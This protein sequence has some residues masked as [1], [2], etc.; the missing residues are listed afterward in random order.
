MRKFLFKTKAENLNYFKTIKDINI[1]EGFHFNKIDWQNDK[2]K[3]LDTISNNFKKKIAIRSS[4]INEDNNENSNAGKYDSFI[5]IKLDRLNIE[6]KIT[7]IFSR[8]ISLKDQ[9]LI[10]EMIL[11]INLSGVIL[12]KEINSG[13]NYYVINYDDLT[14]TTDSITSGKVESKTIFVHKSA[15]K[16]NFKSKRL[17]IIVDHLRKLEKIVGCDHIDIEFILTNKNKFILLQIRKI[18]KNNFWDK[19]LIK[20]IDKKILKNYKKFKENKIY[21]KMADWNPVEMI[22][23]YPNRLSYTLYKYFITDNT[24][25]KSRKKIGYSSPVNTN[26][27]VDICGQPFIDTQKS[28]YSFMASNHSESLKKKIVNSNLSKLKEFPELH[29]KIEFEI[30]ETIF[31]FTNKNQFKSILSNK[32]FNSFKKNLIRHTNHLILNGATEISFLLKK[33]N[34]KN[35]YSKFSK[36]D[37]NFVCDEILDDYFSFGILARHAFIARKLIESFTNLKI[38]SLKRKKEFFKALNS[39]SNTFTI[40]YQ[41]VLSSKMTKLRFMKKYGHLRQGTFDIESKRY[42]KIVNFFD[43]KKKRFN[44]NNDFKLNIKESKQIN[45]LLEKYNI[46]IRANELFDYFS[47]AIKSREESKLIFTKRVSNLLEF[48]KSYAKKIKLSKSDIVHIDFF[49]FLDFLNNK[50]KIVSIYK[51]VLFYK[52]QFK[53]NSNIKL[54]PVIKEKKDF[55]IITTGLN[56]TNF[57]TNNKVK[58]QVINIKNIKNRNEVNNKIVLIKAADPG[59]DWIFTFNIKGLVTMFG[60]LNSHMSIRCFEFDLPAAIGC[61]EKIF[62]EINEKKNITLDCKSKK[63]ECY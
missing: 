4:F 9:I 13:A 48:I 6:K 49:N 14:K 5:N 62:N 2:K 17:M 15:S 46:K 63:I 3:I 11:D 43:G 58:S 10:Q 56:K 25:A 42:D 29:D 38:L 22:G 33:I 44:K 60:G 61:G 37:M 16:I 45:S 26:L 24:W 32:E 50:K 21:S 19:K 54:P 34:E 31:E 1:P 8:S 40:D 52:E 59:Y 53:I 39:I 12:T 27:M 41:K 7:L 20:E 23:E 35:D 30:S 36:K 47:L 55:I 28:F 51:D 57:V 18:T